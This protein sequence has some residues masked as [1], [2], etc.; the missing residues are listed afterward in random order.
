MSPESLR[1]KERIAFA[2]TRRTTPLGLSHPVNF[3]KKA[4]PKLIRNIGKLRRVRPLAAC[5]G[6]CPHGADLA[7]QI[8]GMA[9]NLNPQTPKKPEP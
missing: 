6:R 5:S 3:Y 9:L 7:C 8:W 4:K 2:A 1:D